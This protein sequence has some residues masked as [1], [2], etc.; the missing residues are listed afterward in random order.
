MFKGTAVTSG[1]MESGLLA[2][3]GTGPAWKSY[4]LGLKAPLPETF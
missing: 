4:S 3:M 2:V 1:K